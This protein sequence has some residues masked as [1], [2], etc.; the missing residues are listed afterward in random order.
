MPTVG[1]LTNAGKTKIAQRLKGIG[2]EPSWIG[3]GTGSGTAGVTQTTLFTEASEARVNGT[4]S[5]VT[6]GTTND[7][8]QVDG[9]IT[10]N[11]SKNITNVGNFDAST[12]GSMMMKI[13]FD[14][15]PVEN[16]DTIR[17]IIGYQTVN[18]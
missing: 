5:V 18:P 13:S 8:Y 7:T 3:W 12:G 10:A 15:I 11:G 1:V 4:T 2:T 14:P 9:T 17:F 16:Q 6:T